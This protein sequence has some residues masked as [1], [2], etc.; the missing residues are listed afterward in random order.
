MDVEDDVRS[1]SARVA[2]LTAAVEKSCTVQVES[3][4]WCAQTQSDVAAL[5]AEVHELGRR[6]D[7]MAEVLSRL[8]NMLRVRREAKG[9]SAMPV[10]GGLWD[11]E[12]ESMTADGA[13]LSEI[14]ARIGCGVA[15]VSRRRRHLGADGAAYKRKWTDREDAVLREA[16]KL[17]DSW[18]EVAENLPG[19]TEAAC[20]ARAKRYG[21]RLRHN[22]PHAWTADEDA[23]LRE[24]W[25]SCD[26]ETP[27]IARALGRTE[28]AIRTRASKLGIADS[29]R[30]KWALA[31]SSARFWARGRSDAR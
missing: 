13:S 26:M 29:K 9:T 6:Y 30:R 22:P 17:A 14:A 23:F 18:A 7:N 15:T 21:L 25:V 31:K 3:A 20:C 5:M 24:H 19:R 28:H 16:V 4:G 10:C 12:I 1:L 8:V 11:D 2:R 27:E